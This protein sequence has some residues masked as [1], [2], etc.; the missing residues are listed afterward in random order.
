MG[1]RYK[2]IIHLTQT[3]LQRVLQAPIKVTFGERRYKEWPH[4]NLII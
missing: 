1:F 3:K 4:E 2:L